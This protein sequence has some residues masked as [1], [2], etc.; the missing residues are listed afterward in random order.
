MTFSGRADDEV[1]FLCL[2]S[3]VLN[4]HVFGLII[5]LFLSQVGFVQIGEPCNMYFDGHAFMTH[6]VR[7]PISYDRSYQRVLQAQAGGVPSGGSENDRSDLSVA[8]VPLGSHR[9]HGPSCLGS[10]DQTLLHLM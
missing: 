9:L 5:I 4:I 2:L 8:Q 6:V 3:L 10:G 1:H 7:D